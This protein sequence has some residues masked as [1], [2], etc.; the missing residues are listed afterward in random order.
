MP[1]ALP[2]AILRRF[3]SILLVAADR[4]AT[5]DRPAVVAA[6]LRAFGSMACLAS[7]RSAIEHCDADNRR[8]EAFSKQR[9][10]RV[11]P[12]LLQSVW[13]RRYDLPECIGI[14]RA[15]QIEIMSPDDRL[16][17]SRLEGR[18]PHAA[19]LGDMHGDK[20]VPQTIVANGKLLS[21]LRQKV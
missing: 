4:P 14:P 18:V 2:P 13:L 11:Q 17:I 8:V 15:H 12:K 20:G 9:L 19:E 6:D 5:V 16:R 1:Q 7:L 3:P 10:S 21:N